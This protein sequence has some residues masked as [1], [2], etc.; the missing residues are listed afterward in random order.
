MTTK[1]RPFSK[2]L[3]T[4]PSFWLSSGRPW[5]NPRSGTNPRSLRCMTWDR[6][7]E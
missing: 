3:W 4:M 6:Y 2:S 7:N 5:E 1:R